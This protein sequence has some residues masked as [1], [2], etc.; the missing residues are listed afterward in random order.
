MRCSRSACAAGFLNKAGYRRRNKFIFPASAVPSVVIE[1]PAKIVPTVKHSICCLVLQ[2]ANHSST[3]SAVFAS[4]RKSSASQVIQ[5]PP[6][7]WIHEMLERRLA[8]ITPAIATIAAQ[9]QP[10][11]MLS[12]TGAVSC[13]RYAQ[14]L[15]YLG[16]GWRW[17][18]AAQAWC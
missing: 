15:P 4:P 6:G 1:A 14:G 13:I 11:R 8:Q 3:G 18:A 17:T 10:D 16:S 12:M 5:S 7:R 2:I 9:R